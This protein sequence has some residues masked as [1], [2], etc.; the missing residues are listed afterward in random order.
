[1]L[2]AS[3]A[4]WKHSCLLACW[5]SNQMSAPHILSEII[6]EEVRINLIEPDIYSVYPP[7]A[8]LALS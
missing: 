3:A 6:S 4:S 7:G 2:F 1:M 5:R 8:E